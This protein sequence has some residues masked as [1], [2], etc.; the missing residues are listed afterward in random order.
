MAPRSPIPAA[1]NPFIKAMN[2]MGYDAMTLGNH[3]FNFGKDVFT[4]VLGQATFPLLQANV[5][6]DGSYG[7]AAAN[8]QPYVEKSLGDIDVA[9]LGIGNHRIPNYELPS[10][11]P[12]LTFSDPIVKTQE[13]LA[14]FRPT[15]DV[16]VALTHIGFTENP[17]GSGCQCGHKP[18]SPDHRG[19]CGG[20]RSQPH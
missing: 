6:D 18:G 15:N 16:V 12:G 20:R 10:N 1:I 17:G 19:R 7:L 2:T 9:I 13:L 3:E 4:S 5:T 11:I 14:L 8:I